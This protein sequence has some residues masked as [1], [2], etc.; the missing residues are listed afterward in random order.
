MWIILLSGFNFS[1]LQSEISSLES[2]ANTQ[3]VGEELDAVLIYLAVLEKSAHH[4]MP[5]DRG[6]SGDGTPTVANA[7]VRSNM[8]AWE[9]CLLADA[10][11]AATVF[12]GIGLTLLATPPTATALI[13]A[14][15]WSAGVHH[16]G[17]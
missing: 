8:A 7:S 3:L 5:V 13:A 2:D 14:V 4:W 1:D 16:C 6:G 15:G 11:A 12:T 17:R 9:R 10:T